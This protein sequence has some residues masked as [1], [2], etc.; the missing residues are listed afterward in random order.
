MF[1]TLIRRF[2]ALQEACEVSSSVKNTGGG[3][4][5]VLG[6]SKMILAG[7]QGLVIPADTTDIVA[8]IKEQ[9]HAH[10]SARV[11]PFFGNAKP[12]WNVVDNV[13][14]DIS[15]TSEYT[16]EIVYIRS[17]V[18]NR[19]YQTT[20]GGLCLAKTLISFRNSGKFF[21]EVDKDGNY[22]LYKN[23]D[24]TYS[25]IP[26]LN[27]GGKSPTIATGT[28][29]FKNRF[30]LSFDGDAYINATIFSDGLGLLD[31]KGLE[32][33][34][35]YVDDDSTPSTTTEIYVNVKTE[36]GSTD[37]VDL[38]STPLADVDNFIITKVEDGSIV[39]PSAA[40]IVDGQIQLTGVYEAGKD[41][42]V[43]LASAADL[44]ANDIVYYEGQTKATVSIPA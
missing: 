23:S 44:Y 5:K 14:D 28:T 34:D 40:A 24:G 41:Y 1:N 30:N 33:V 37:L 11:Y 19:E 38:L 6:P 17:G 22:M 42:T 4:D 7:P 13:G 25:F 2:F 36:C 26:T 21:M 3:C 16:G 15:E 9:I 29:Q 27:L 18:I 35:V 43:E 31:L 8:Y 20:K 39:T 32:D 12:L 10:V